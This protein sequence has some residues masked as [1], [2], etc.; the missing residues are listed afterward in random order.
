MVAIKHRL[1]LV[2][3][4]SFAILFS[5][6]CHLEIGQLAPD[7]SLKDQNDSLHALSNYRGNKIAIY[8]YPKDN[9]PGCIKEACSIRDN[10]SILKEN[11]IKILGISYDNAENHL[12][13]INK[14]NL[15]FDL[16]SDLDK[17][18]SKQYCAKGWFMPQR[19]TILIDEKGIIVYIF[20]EVNVGV[21]GF[22]IFEIFYPENNGK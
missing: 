22:E 6:D 19:K 12:M 8:F 11:N 3:T 21:H 15:P 16:L 7:F 14:H 1:Y 18:V 2:T 5:Y 17:S 20:E 9:T 4:I 13:F 10:F